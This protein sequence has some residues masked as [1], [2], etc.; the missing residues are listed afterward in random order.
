M[1]KAFFLLATIFSILAIHAF[2]QENSVKG[3]VGI[4]N[5]DNGT[6]A[7]NTGSGHTA[8]LNGAEL[9]MLDGN[10]YCVK[11]ASKAEPIT[12]SA[13]SKSPL[14]VKS[15]TISF[16]INASKTVN[17]NIVDYDNGAFTLRSYRGYLQPR[18][19]G[20]GKFKFS[21]TVL[22]DQW[23]KHLIRED[24]FYPI[25]NALIEENKWHHFTVAFDY[26][27]R[28]FIGWRDGELIAEVDLSGTG[29]EPLRTEES[30]KDS[31]W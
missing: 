8:M 25:D 24:A 26:K 31:N 19:R 2:A 28:K 29:V 11:F 4:W 6:G 18:F 22:N 13:D 10:G 17:Y 21:S 5:F 27:N 15:G 23:Y 3:L 9:Y 12:I 1:K 16:W 14:A 7:D 30:E 20:E